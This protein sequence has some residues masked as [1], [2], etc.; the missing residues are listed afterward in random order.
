[1]NDDDSST[2]HPRLLKSNIM[3]QGRSFVLLSAQKCFVVA[4]VW[5]CLTRET[6]RDKK[7]LVWGD[8]RNVEERRQ[9]PN[10]IALAILSN[11]CFNAI[12]RPTHIKRYTIPVLQQWWWRS[13]MPP[14]KI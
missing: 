6:R 12:R 5:W 3:D 1:V 8:T 2:R 13:C 4:R 9:S 10:D 14:R 7:Y 11:R